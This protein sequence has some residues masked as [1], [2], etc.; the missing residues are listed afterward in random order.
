MDEILIKNLWSQALCETKLNGD[1]VIAFA[2]LI[3]NTLNQTPK[4]LKPGVV[5]DDGCVVIDVIGS[6]ALIAAPKET[7]VICEWSQ[8]FNPAFNKL[9]EKGFNP[10]GWFIPSENQLLL[11]Y[12]KAYNH[13][14]PSFYWSSTEASSTDAC[15]VSFF[16]GNQNTYSKTVAFCVRTFRYIEL[17]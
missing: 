1:P 2:R 6:E 16:S 10:I 11:A 7:E 14:W 4:T 8:N 12:K 9:K 5:L 3:E 17:P 15:Y 13:F